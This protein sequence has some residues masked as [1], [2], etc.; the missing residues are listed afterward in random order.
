MRRMLVPLVAVAL[1]FAGSACSTFGTQPAATVDGSEISAK[2]LTDEVKIIRDNNAYRQVL[3]QSYGAPTIGGGKGTF[4]AAFVAQLLSLRVWYAAIEKDLDRRGLEVTP[5]VLSQATDEM[6]QQFSQLGPNVFKGF[7]AWYRDKLV[8]QRALIDV[9]ERDVAKKIGTDP[10]DFYDANKDEFA[11]ICVSHALVGTQGGK[12]P[13]KAQAEAQKLYDSIESGDLTFDEVATQHSDDPGAAS[14]QG[15]LGCGSKLSLQFDP[16]FE[17]A[18]FALKPNQV[19]EPVQTQFGS[20]LILVTSRKVPTYE[21]V[22]DQVTT[23]M[24]QAH[25]ERI[26]TYLTKVICNG[27]VSVN[28]RYGTW[29][30]QVCDGL[31]PQLPQVRPPEGPAGATTTTVP[32]AQG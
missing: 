30:S 9:V 22:Q 11:E 16:T 7:P 18:A 21:E 15:A 4:D 31:A 25:D 12:S 24:Q 6:E 28:P 8:K 3:E 2:S 13:E 5:D 19:S 10:K 17:T 1:A 32:S 23:V 14:Q 26:N 29:A 20:H 27:D